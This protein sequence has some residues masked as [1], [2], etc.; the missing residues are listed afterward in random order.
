MCLLDKGLEDTA[1]ESLSSQLSTFSGLV[2]AAKELM[3]TKGECAFI[4][5]YEYIFAWSIK[6]I[7]RS[8]IVMSL[9]NS[10][11]L[12]VIGI[13][14][15]CFHL[16]ALRESLAQLLKPFLMRT[17][18][19]MQHKSTAVLSVRLPSVRVGLLCL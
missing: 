10:C 15:S 11:H 2:K 12:D 3:P 19:A 7:N 13:T 8:S 6:K 4:S 18:H 5:F 16:S 17:N 14:G 9:I 1:G